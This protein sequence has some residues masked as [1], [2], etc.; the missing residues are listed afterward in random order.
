MAIFPLL[1]TAHRRKSTPGYLPVCLP[2]A[3]GRELE[4]VEEDLL[5]AEADDLKTVLDDLRH[6][7]QG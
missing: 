6:F 7:L 3:F 2:L 4:L 1:N 5:L